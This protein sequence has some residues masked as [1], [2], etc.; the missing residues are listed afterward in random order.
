MIGWFPRP[1]WH[2]GSQRIF[3]EWVWPTWF[4]KWEKSWN[5]ARKP[6]NATGTTQTLRTGTIQDACTPQGWEW[7]SLPPP[8]A[9]DLPESICGPAAG[10][11][12]PGGAGLAG[13]PKARDRTGSPHGTREEG[14]WSIWGVRGPYHLF[15]Q[16]SPPETGMKIEFP[17]CT[18]GKK[19]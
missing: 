10:G 11:G 12:F 18:R 14:W 9:I 8:G 3:Y 6:P 2:S 17:P 1:I 7:A 13:V 5:F 19:T 4:Q 16:V 15:P